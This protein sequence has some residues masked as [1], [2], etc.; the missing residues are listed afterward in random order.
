MMKHNEKNR[1]ET[2]RNNNKETGRTAS[3]NPSS[4]KIKIEI[5]QNNNR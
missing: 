5:E 2:A 4:H 1:I 3:H